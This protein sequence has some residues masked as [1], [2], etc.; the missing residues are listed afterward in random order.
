M[1][2][3]RNL[4]RPE[5]SSVQQALGLFGENANDRAEKILGDPGF[6]DSWRRVQSFDVSGGLLDGVP[7]SQAS[8]EVTA[9]HEVVDLTQDA[10]SVALLWDD[11]TALETGPKQVQA[12][13]IVRLDVTAE[14]G[15]RLEVW[16]AGWDSFG[17]ARVLRRGDAEERERERAAAEQAAAKDV[18][19]LSDLLKGGGAVFALVGLV[20]LVILLKT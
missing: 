5:P 7:A 9:A 8:I 1:I 2:G 4:L 10:L 11:A 6:L 12:G 16:V 13:G 19:Q 18:P 14:R 3:D 15:N 17:A 20:A